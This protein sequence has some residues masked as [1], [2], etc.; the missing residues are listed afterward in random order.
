ML[1]FCAQKRGGILRRLIAIRLLGDSAINRR[2]CRGVIDTL[3]ATLA[4]SKCPET[5]GTNDDLEGNHHTTQD[6][7]EDVEEGDIASKIIFVSNGNIGLGAHTR[8]AGL[9]ES[10]KD[11]V[12]RVRDAVFLYDYELG[13]LPACGDHIGTDGATLENSDTATGVV[14]G[15]IGGVYRGLRG[16]CTVEDQEGKSNEHDEHDDS[17]PNTHSVC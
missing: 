12:R 8:P 4:R 1:L 6:V 17:E 14:V 5:D 7:E 2:Q 15:A 16:P 13:I 9:S 3:Y 11:I 10:A